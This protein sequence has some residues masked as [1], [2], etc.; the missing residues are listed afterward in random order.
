MTIRKDFVFKLLCTAEYGFTLLDG[1][2]GIM[3]FEGFTHTY[4]LLYFSPKSRSHAFT[5]SWDEENDASEN[6][7]R[8]SG[9][10][11]D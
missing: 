4:Q 1:E 2:D 7:R 6:P 8:R 11:P 10:R 3:S 9:S 5:V